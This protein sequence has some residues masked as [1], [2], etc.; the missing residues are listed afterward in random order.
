MTLMERLRAIVGVSAPPPRPP[1]TAPP[2]PMDATSEPAA[3]VHEAPPVP[4]AGARI[5]PEQ[6]DAWERDGYLVLPGFYSEADIDGAQD[7][8][9][10]AW[11]QK[12]PRIV[13]DDLITNE[14]LRLEDV[15][16]AHARDHRFKVNDLYMELE[17]VRG[18][19][20]NPRL[21]PILHALLDEAPVIVNSL[22][23]EQGSMQPDHVDALYMAPITPGKLVAIW[24]ALEDCRP[25][26][27]PL[28]YYPGSH[29]IDQYRFSNGDTRAIHD[30]MPAWTA[31]MYEQSGLRGLR[32]ETFAARK[33]DV[34]IWSAYLMHGGSEITDPSSTRRSIVF[35]Y[36]S[37]SDCRGIGFD[38]VPYEGG[39]WLYRRHQAVAGAEGDFPPRH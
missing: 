20:L 12:A 6:R 14:R 33:G 4:A 25:E 22:N 7:F 17:A 23:F 38:L 31:Y 26:A 15:P 8:A 32:A 18:L 29:K 13:V 36:L 5:A 10:D 34:F 3:D 1:V 16:A 11:R 21:T 35:H 27:G 37:E 28:R 39:F 30:E 2:L 9:A 24:V 19:A